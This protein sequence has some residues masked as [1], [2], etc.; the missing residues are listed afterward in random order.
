MDFLEL[1]NFYVIPGIVLGSIY[2]LGAVGITLIFAILRYAHLAHGDLAT[3][4]AF[5]ALAVVTG[6]GVSPLLA[7]PIAIIAT[8]AVAV[9]IDKVFY[10]HLRERPKIVTVMASLGIALMIRAVVQVVW[11]VDTETYS[12]GIVRPENYFGLRIRDREILTVIAMLALVGGLQLFLT[13]SK[14]GKAMR[15]MSDNPNLA[16]L[17]GIDNKKVVMLTWV[18]AGGLCAA[19]GVFLGLN[20]ELK[21]LMGWQMLLPMFAAAI[22]GGVG[23]IE[24]AVLGGLIVGIAEELSVLVIPSEYKAAMAFAILLFMLLVR[25]TGLLKGKVL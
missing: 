6:L 8:A 22:L 3:L 10:E 5:I 2:A 16:L 20:T 17:S 14:W 12:R 23:R 4:G 13:R 9:G 21:S 18:I 11:G 7:L 15:A 24:G 25:P 1:I 19:S